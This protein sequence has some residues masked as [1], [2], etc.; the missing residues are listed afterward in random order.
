MSKKKPENIETSFKIFLQFFFLFCNVNV[1]S[2]NYKYAMLILTKLLLLLRYL[3]K[4][5][6]NAIVIRIKKYLK[7]KCSKKQL[8]KL[9]RNMLKNSQENI[10]N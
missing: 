3:Q 1:I 2:S 4:K 7:L 6:F 10:F 9:T 8:S 5:Y